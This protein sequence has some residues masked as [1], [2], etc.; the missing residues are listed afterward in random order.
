MTI[1]ARK[2]I[3]PLGTITLAADGDALC[4]LWFDGQKYYGGAVA[5]ALCYED[6][7]AFTPVRRWLDDYFAG[8]RP[9]VTQLKLRPAGISPFR[10]EVWRCLLE[11]PYGETVTYGEIARKIALRRGIA[12]MSAQ[13]VGGAV[14]HNP[15]SIIVPC[16][17]VVGASGEL[18]GYAGGFARKTWLL[19]FEKRT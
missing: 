1:A 6:S 4:G 14:G 2:Y 18:T 12:S 3:S 11:I 5:S 8:K 16:H 10:A 7:A 9:S 13:A 19:D 15:L 17:R